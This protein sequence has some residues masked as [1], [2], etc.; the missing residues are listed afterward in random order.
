MNRIRRE[1]SISLAL[2]DDLLDMATIHCNYE[3]IAL[4]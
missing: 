4:S 2:N 1:Y 3:F